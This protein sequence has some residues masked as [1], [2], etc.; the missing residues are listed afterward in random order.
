MR[1]DKESGGVRWSIK[2][3]VVTGGGFKQWQGLRGSRTGTAG[4]LA[5]G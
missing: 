2:A 1:S 5:E 3:D 4:E